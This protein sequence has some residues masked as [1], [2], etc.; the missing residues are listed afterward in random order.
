MKDKQAFSIKARAASF[1]YAFDGIE[2][3]FISEPN[4]VLHLLGTIAVL[5]LALAVHVSRIEMIALVFGIGLV[6]IAELFNTAIEKIMDLIS[7]QYHPKIKF[8]K[9]LS[10]GAVLVAAIIALVIGGIVFIPKL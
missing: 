2:R 8:I 1:K 9:D 4:A 3:F 10:A 5:I 6:W 7:E